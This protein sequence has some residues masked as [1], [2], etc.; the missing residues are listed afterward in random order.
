VAA[1]SAGARAERVNRNPSRSSVPLA[2]GRTAT[3]GA[4]WARTG[5]AAARAGGRRHGQTDL[6][7]TLMGAG[8]VTIAVA[9]AAFGEAKTAVQLGGAALVFRPGHSDRA[10]EPAQAES[11]AGEQQHERSAG[12]GHRDLLLDG[13]G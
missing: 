6:L 13:L 5:R 7:A 1:D 2:G 10:A 11:G 8:S 3:P 9:A 12:E 4:P